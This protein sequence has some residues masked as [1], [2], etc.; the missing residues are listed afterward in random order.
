MFYPILTA[1]I[2]LIAL[3]VYFTMFLKVAQQRTK[4]QIAGSDL[5][6]PMPKDLVLA[7]RV[8]IN[9]TEH[10]VLFLPLLWMAAS[11]TT[12]RFA[13]TIGAVWVIGRVL[14][15]LGYYKSFKQRWP[16][17]VINL[18]AYLFLFGGIVWGII[19]YYQFM[20]VTTPPAG[21]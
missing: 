20:A 3:G 16:G 5:T 10:L 12:D 14:Y 2:T 8:Q 19:Q 7:H 1:I 4:H 9:T 6:T 13:A 21:L 15:A 18:I 11:L 17:F